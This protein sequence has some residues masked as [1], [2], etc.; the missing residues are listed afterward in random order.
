MIDGNFCQSAHDPALVRSLVRCP[1]FQ[2]VSE[3]RTVGPS[4]RGSIRH[5]VQASALS[6]IVGHAF[7]VF[8]L[9]LLAPTQVCVAADSGYLAGVHGSVRASLTFLSLD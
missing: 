7:M 4:R 8:L 3:E 6:L 1:A 2:Q 9:P 5:G